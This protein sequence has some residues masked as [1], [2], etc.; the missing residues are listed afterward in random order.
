MKRSEALEVL[1]SHRTDQIVVSTMSVTTEWEDYSSTEWDLY[2]GDAMGQATPVGLGLA[3]AQPDRQ[4]WVFNGDGS[5]LMTLG[6]LVTVGDMSPTNLIVFIFRND[7]YE[8]TGGQ[9]IPGAGKISFPDIARGAGFPRGYTFSEAGEMAGMLD[10][11]V[12]GRG[13]VL[14]DLH[15][16]GP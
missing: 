15:V 2:D 1:A 3:L 12:G 8:I 5:Q 13:P 11:V 9:P 16:E 6:S 10:Y 7:A 14:V 4:I